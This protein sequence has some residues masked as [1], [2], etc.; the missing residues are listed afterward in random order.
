MI[1]HSLNAALMLTIELMLAQKF[2][3]YMVFGNF[4]EFLSQFC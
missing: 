1:I 4:V 3:K 2:L